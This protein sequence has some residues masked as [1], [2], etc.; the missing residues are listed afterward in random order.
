MLLRAGK[1]LLCWFVRES[2]SYVS[3]CGKVAL[4]LVSAGKWLLC[5]IVRESG[6]YVS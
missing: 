4:I 1:R 2:G 6:F 3:S 5:W